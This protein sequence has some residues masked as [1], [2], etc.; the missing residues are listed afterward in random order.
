MANGSGMRRVLFLMLA[1]LCA[2]GP[3]LAKNLDVEVMVQPESPIRVVGCSVDL[4]ELRNG[5]NFSAKGSFED[6]GPKTA[7]AVR[8]GFAF[9]DALGERRIFSGLTTGTYTPGARIDVHPF[10]GQVGTEARKLVC[11]ALQ[12]G[13]SD[14]TVWKATQYPLENQSAAA[15]PAQPTTA[16]PQPALAAP[17]A[18]ATEMLQPENGPVRFERCTF[19]MP[20]PSVLT[21]LIVLTNTSDKRIQSADIAFVLYT[22]DGKASISHSVLKGDF[23]PG[24]PI[25]G[26]A[27]TSVPGSYAKAYCAVGI[28]EYADGT[29]W[30]PGAGFLKRA[31]PP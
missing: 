7:T 11:F 2:T 29:K 8:I 10:G 14:G 25:A 12:A 15:G 31:T 18:I 13:F 5:Q 19:A 17:G 16:A 3:A 28:V 6:I 4:H 20:R 23:A 30:D 21:K 1:F 22:S 9:F 26:Q 24:A 27:T